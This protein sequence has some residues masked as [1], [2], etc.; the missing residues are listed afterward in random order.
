MARRGKARLGES[1]VSPVIA[2][3]LMVGITVVLAAGAYLAFRIYF[4]NT[5]EPA[6]NIGY[7]PQENQDRLYIATA[8]KDA[9][10]GDLEI[11]TDL[12]ARVR[13]NGP[14]SL[15]TG[16]LSP[17]GAFVPLAGGPQSVGGGEYVSV[18]AIGLPGD[19]FL[20]IRDVRA[21]AVTYEQ[22]LDVE[23]CT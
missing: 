14:A 19:V 15:L 23:T 12:P 21:Q 17:G 10:W 7:W 4:E 2:T 13:L 9:D 6:P 16:T 22:T 5:P 8:E 18:C 11:Q 3:I 1:G 20:R